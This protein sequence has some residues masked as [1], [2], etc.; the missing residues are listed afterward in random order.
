MKTINFQNAARA[1]QVYV[2]T[3]QPAVGGLSLLPNSLRLGLTETQPCS[4][5]EQGLWPA[6]SSPHPLQI[7]SS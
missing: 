4:G 1:R 2:Q 5:T 3:T 6:V 7:H